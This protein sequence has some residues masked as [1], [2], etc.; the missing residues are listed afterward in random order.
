MNLEPDKS[1][2]EYRAVREVIAVVTI[3]VLFYL[4]YQIRMTLLPIGIAFLLSY[5]VEPPVR[6]LHERARIP[7]GV[8][9]TFS[10]LV[11]LIIFVVFWGWAT[12]RFAEQANDL[13]EKLPDYVKV[14]R[15]RLGIE[16]REVNAF[17]DS[18]RQSEGKGVEQAIQL[19]DF[20]IVGA[21]RTFGVVGTVAATTFYLGAAFLLMAVFFFVFVTYRGWGEHL[22]WIIPNNHRRT[23]K[24]VLGYMD[25]ALGAYVRGQLLVALFTFI[26]F[27]V[28]FFLAD[29]PYWFLV[30]LIGGLFS[31]IPYGQASGPIL[32]ISLKFLDSQT[33][34][35]S[36]SLWGVLLAPLVVYAITQSLETWVITPLV[37]GEINK[38]RPTVI[39]IVLILGGAIAG[40]LGLILAIPITATVNASIRELIFKERSDRETGP[41]AG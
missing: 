1:L 12:P 2:W 37:Q 21:K 30:A 40:V 14:L 11:F 18:I 22:E 34:D 17:I 15:D 19:S 9:A 16:R 38:L 20:V 28:G 33:G 41:L 36:F 26:G 13:I 32:A 39:I 25:R 10:L 27:S 29:V 31:L 4:A 23:A 24:T 7:R 6:I 3:G 5:A 8:S 35:G